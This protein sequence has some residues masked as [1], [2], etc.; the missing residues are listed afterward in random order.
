MTK[1]NITDG[2]NSLEMSMEYELSVE[3]AVQIARHE[4]TDLK[5]I[6]SS[7][8]K[9]SAQIRSE[10]IEWNKAIKQAERE[11]TMKDLIARKERD[12]LRQKEE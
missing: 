7:I 6:V 3:E 11:E 2:T 12:D 9:A 10:C 8:F 1:L 5:E 4:L